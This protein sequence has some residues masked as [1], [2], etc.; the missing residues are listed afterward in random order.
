LAPL[1]FAVVSIAGCELP[2]NDALWVQEQSVPIGKVNFEQCVTAAV[3]QVSGVSI[4]N[5]LAGPQSKYMIALN[6][7][8]EK[9]VPFLGVDVQQRDN[10]T[11]VIMFSHKAGWF[12]EP[13]EVRKEITPV[14]QS[15]ADAISRK[16][17]VGQKQNQTK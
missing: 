5:E 2:L 4:N 14:L 12:G 6:V 11:A 13:D 10:G 9:P 17:G 7:K 8:L 16:C 1:L 3:S 15:I